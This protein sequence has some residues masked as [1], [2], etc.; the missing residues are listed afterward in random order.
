MKVLLLHNRYVQPGGED[1]VFEDEARLL[2]ERGVS[3]SRLE[4]GNED[5]GSGALNR[6]VSIGWNAPWSRN[7]YATVL[8]LCKE[9]QPDIA[10]VHNFW[11]RLTPSVHAACRA[12][13]V[14][15][16]QT[17]HNFRLLCA[18]ANFLRDG[19]ICQDCLGKV[20]WRGVVRK[21]YRGSA[22]ASAAVAGMVMTN[23]LRRTWERDVDAFIAL[24]A[25]SRAKFVTAGLPAERVFVKPNFAMEPGRG[26]PAPSASRNVVFAGRLSPE[27]GARVLVEAWVAGGLAA[28]GHLLIVGD[29]PE[30]A[31]LER[32]AGGSPNIAFLGAR[33]PEEVQ[34]M[35]LAARTV[36]VP[37]MC[38]ENFPRVIAEA[39]ACGRP[40]IGSALGAVGEIVRDGECGLTF[41]HGDVAA[42]GRALR[43]MLTD[44]GLADR[45]GAQARDE[46]L[47]K[48]TADRNFEMLLSVYRSARSRRAAVE[49][50][51]AFA[52]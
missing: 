26:G 39:F 37:S 45:L 35:L 44:D 46:F 29:G 43:G 38:F 8:A 28:C 51:P 23:R 7:S 49:A 15:T 17:L 27:K 34:E 3:V 13:G 32:V 40:V 10:H 4:L 52:S 25:H 47:R 36:V 33:R 22:L 20:P 2:T 50:E 18:N 41:P 24:S 30:R 16:V 6:L 21:C 19:A 1:A 14:P 48:Y 42:L 5:A 9:L 11:M 31:E 12:A